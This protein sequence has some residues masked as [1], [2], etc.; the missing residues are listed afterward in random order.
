MDKAQAEQ[1][2]NGY[3]STELEYLGSKNYKYRFIDYV[4]EEFEKRGR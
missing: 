2:I 1:L 3:G 4:F